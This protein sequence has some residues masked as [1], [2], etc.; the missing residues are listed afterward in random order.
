MRP[1]LPASSLGL[2][3]PSSNG[4]SQPT[5][6]SARLDQRIGVV[7][8]HDEARF[9][10]HKVRILGRLRQI[11]TSTRSPPISFAMVPK[12]GWSRRHS[13]SRGPLPAPARAARHQQSAKLGLHWI[14]HLAACFRFNDSTIQFINGSTSLEF[15][16]AVRSQEE[17]ELQPDE[18][19]SPVNCP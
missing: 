3:A 1:G 7:E 17:F 8:L 13:I 15:V 11:V 14:W 6:N 18:W 16:R 4:G 10:I 9:R 5:S 2:R 19:S 12:S